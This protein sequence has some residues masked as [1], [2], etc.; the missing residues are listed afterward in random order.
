MEQLISPQKA[1]SILSV[2]TD[3]LRNWELSG[4]LACIKTLGGHRRYK[5]RDIEKLLQNSKKN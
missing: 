5:L 2:S 3:T 4:K 1:A